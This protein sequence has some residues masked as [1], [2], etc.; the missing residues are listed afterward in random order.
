[1]VF[2]SFGYNFF[3]IVL[4]IWYWWL[5]K[6]SFRCFK[7]AGESYVKV[8]F[9]GAVSY[10]T[11]AVLPFC[12]VLAVVWAVYRRVSFAWIGQDILVRKKKKTKG[13]CYLPFLTFFFLSW[14][15]ICMIKCPTYLRAILLLHL[16]LYAFYFSYIEK[17]CFMIHLN[18]IFLR[19]NRVFLFIDVY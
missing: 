5:S 17:W 3:A 18:M 1:M 15:F 10:L 6:Y 16:L 9:L 8:P 4:Q 2:P 13:S 12:I 14:I 7:H 11:L 19:N